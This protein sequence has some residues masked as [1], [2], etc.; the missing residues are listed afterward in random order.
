VRK[1]DYTFV[2]SVHPV[3]H[4]TSCAKKRDEESRGLFGFHL[5]TACPDCRVRDVGFE[6]W[7]E[8]GYRQGGAR[9]RHDLAHCLKARAVKQWIATTDAEYPK[10]S[11]I[12]YKFRVGPQIYYKERI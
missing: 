10:G 7:G 6:L 5:F 2:I 1:P 11:L 3:A 4:V 9:D 8:N 12:G